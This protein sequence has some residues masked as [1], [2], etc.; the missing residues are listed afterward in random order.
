[1]KKG[2]LGIPQRLCLDEN[3]KRYGNIAHSAF[4]VIKQSALR[5]NTLAKRRCY[6]IYGVI[7]CSHHKFVKYFSH[8]F[9][10]KFVGIFI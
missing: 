3:K 5:E 1:M 10:K 7:I 6:F 9:R 4:A 8:I 2:A